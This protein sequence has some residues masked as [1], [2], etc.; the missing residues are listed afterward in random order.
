MT[1]RLWPSPNDHPYPRPVEARASGR[2]NFLLGLGA[3]LVAAV[4]G[5]IWLYTDGGPRAAYVAVL[6]VAFGV[7]VF[8]HAWSDQKKG[9]RQLAIEMSAD[10]LTIPELFDETVPWSEVIHVDYRHPSLCV[11]IRDE[12]R[13]KPTNSRRIATLAHAAACPNSGPLDVSPKVLF[14][15][16]QA[17]RAHFG[18]GGHPSRT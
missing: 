1:S 12:E 6:G 10:G 17:H 18:N 11:E 16:L 4:S 3:L 13:F 5:L 9:A 8:L 15:A 7:M 2:H 14:E